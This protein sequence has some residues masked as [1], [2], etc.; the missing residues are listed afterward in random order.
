MVLLGLDDEVEDD[1]RWEEEWSGSLLAL[2]S[3]SD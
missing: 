1:D 2:F 3:R